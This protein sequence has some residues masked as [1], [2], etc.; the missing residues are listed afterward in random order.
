MS[1][2]TATRLI[3][4]FAVP[5]IALGLSACGS[6]E[7]PAASTGG[8]EEGAAAALSP[9]D[10]ILASVENL[11]AESYKMESSMTV[12]GTEFMAMTGMYGGDNSQ[13]GAD[14]F[15]SAMLEASGEELTAEDQ[16]LMGDMFGDMHTET[17]VVDKVMY[18][19]L[20]GGMYDG[21]ADAYG[22]DAWFTM[23]LAS[24]DA[25]AQAFSEYGGMDLGEQ[26]ELVLTELT[27]VEETG[28]GVYTGTLNADS[29]ALSALAGSGLGM[30]SDAGS[31]ATGMIEGTEVTVTLDGDGLLK[32]MTMTMPEVEG[33]AM[34]MTSEIVEIGGSYDI[35]APESTNLHD[36]DEFLSG[37]GAGM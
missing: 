21:M 20:S 30:G 11:N 7:K 12:D 2:R 37:M 31:E 3:G 4:A 26:T 28:D 9:Q 1:S 23:D 27:D 18:M 8:D 34:E 10:A 19:Q 33:M 22:E 17:I 16:E 6:D 35:K 13:A 36:F 14:I 29:E 5:A 25:M 24:D 15:M 32:S